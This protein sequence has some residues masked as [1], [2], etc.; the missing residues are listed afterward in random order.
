MSGALVAFN[1]L[2]ISVNRGEIDV[3]F[4]LSSSVMSVVENKFLRSGYLQRGLRCI[5]E[6]FSIGK[7]AFAIIHV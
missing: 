7:P 6:I 3:C 2:K 4:F 1:V 5:N